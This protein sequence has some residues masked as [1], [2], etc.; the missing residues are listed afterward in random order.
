MPSRIERIETIR[1]FDQDVKVLKRKHYDLELMLEPIRAIVDGDHELLASRFRDHALTGEWT[2]YRELHITGD[3]LLV[4]FIDDGGLVLVLTRAAT[5]DELYSSKSPKKII[6]T[7]RQVPR[8][9][10]R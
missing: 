4:Y 3:W 9:R 7:Y 5:H 1:A 8:R 10:F 2:G 6:K